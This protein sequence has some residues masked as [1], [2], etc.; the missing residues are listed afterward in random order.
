MGSISI[1]TTKAV[2]RKIISREKSRLSWD[3][4]PGVVGEKREHHLCAM[5]THSPP[6]NLSFILGLNQKRPF[7]SVTIFKTL[8][9]SL[10][11]SLERLDLIANFYASKQEY[12][13]K[14]F[15]RKEL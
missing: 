5:P 15:R 6:P 14:K 7:V 2:K 10:A 13:G 3:S 11:V 1:L 8:V 4:N 9:H 12:E